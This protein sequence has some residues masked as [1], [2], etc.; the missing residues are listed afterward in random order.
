MLFRSKTMTLAQ[1]L[2]EGV[3]IKGETTG[4]ITYMRTDSTNLSKEAIKDIRDFLQKDFGENYLP[5]TH[6]CDLSR[7]ADSLVR[8]QLASADDSRTW[9]SALLW[10]R[11]RRAAPYRRLEN[12]IARC[13]VG[14]ETTRRTASS[15]AVNAV[16]QNHI[17]ACQ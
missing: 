12:L 2:Y 3:S 10:L 16:S 6:W 5:K 9:L 11:L 4:L 15:Y 8:A 17:L 1:K 7:S 14:I 13:A